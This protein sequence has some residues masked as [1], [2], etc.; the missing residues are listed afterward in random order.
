MPPP[1]AAAAAAAAATMTP[2]SPRSPATPG[3][4]PRGGGQARNAAAA[5]AG[6][7]VPPL[8][9]VTARGDPSQLLDALDRPVARQQQPFDPIGFLNAHYETE[10]ALAQ[11][12]PALREAVSGRMELLNDR[13]ST[14]LQR[15]S[16]TAGGTAGH[17]RD[18]RES[19]AALRRRVLQVRDKAAASE[20]AVLE[21]TAD[22]KRLD[23][24]KRHLQRTITTLKRLHMLVHAVEQLRLTVRQEPFPDYKTASHLIDAIEELLHHFE[25]YTA[26]VQPMR[27]LE[28]KVSDYKQELKQSVQF[29]FRV[30]AYGHAKAEWLT[31]GK[32]AA[33]AKEE[34]EEETEREE[35]EHMP[36]MTPDI[37]RGGVL[38]MDALGDSVRTRFIHEFCEDCLTD[39]CKEFEPPDRQPKQQDRPRVSSFKVQAVEPE[40]EKTQTCLNAVET[41][42]SWFL[43]KPLKSIN[44]IF[45]SVFP[46]HWNLQASMAAMFLQLT[47]DH[48][49]ALLDGPRKDPD[50]GNATILLKALQKTIQFEKDIT[51]WLEREC[52]A[53]FETTEELQGKTEQETDDRKQ[54]PLP[55]LTG[56]ASAAYQ[57]YMDPYIRLEEQS[58]DEQL[59]EA[60]EDKTVDTRGERPVFTSSTNLFVYMKGSITRCTALTK[61]NA[62]FLLYCAFKDSLRKYAQI[63][64][65]KLPKPV[66]QIGGVGG[67]QIP[68]TFA[69][70]QDRDQQGTSASY[71]LAKGEE[72]TACHVISTCEYCADTME[73]LE[74]LI[75]DTIDEEYQG[76][77]D[78]MSDQE[79]FHDITAKAIRVLVSGLTNRLETAMKTM[80]STNWATWD[81]VGEESAYVYTIHVEVEPFVKTVKNLLPTSYFR[82]F[83]DKFAN[84]FTTMYYENIIRLK[85]VSEP[86]TQQLLLDAYNLKT[87][88]LK[89][90]VLEDAAAP[91]KKAVSTGASIAPAMYTKIVQ[92][93][94]GRIET[95]LKLVGTPNDLLIENFKVQ[96]PGGT[97][98]DLQ[99][100]MS[101]K[102]L[103]RG[104]Q[105][106]MLEKLGLD[107]S[108]ALKG[109]TSGVT[110][111]TIV[112]EHVQALQDQGS[113]VAAKV[114]SDLTQMRQKVDEFRKTFR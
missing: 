85:R 91:G 70:K 26:K 112:S 63:L 56:V 25:A 39:Y 90:P 44:S 77:I 18:A 5:L 110:G 40:P 69:A 38:L 113:N 86:G 6:S 64:D 89:L 107:P 76:K 4:S 97:A 93:Q 14:A 1:P 16:E 80:S 9:V 11:Q 23:C 67:I 74:D 42:F 66:A 46:S 22:M 98:L 43:N 105:A 95:T 84:A 94:F 58:M 75:R 109:A 106:A 103:K 3:R 15:Q 21:I 99:I 48:I 87:L 28:G 81:A 108:S 7:S 35:E 111:A 78:M 51:G 65:S 79:N 68:G 17:V 114:N 29:G 34:E 12:L 32:K 61:G 10:S 92:K 33:V 19:V 62:F 96:W 54:T 83:C 82:S 72:V 55:P 53:V 27:I 24:A 20:R 73:A 88:F 13:V 2:L 45:P 57:N 8:P 100:I 102:G 101:L 52:G 31:T 37:M 59:V 47:R 36:V 30:V 41:R 104:E 50:A 71:R 49:L 60:L